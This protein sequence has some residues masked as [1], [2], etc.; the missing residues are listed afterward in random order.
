MLVGNLLNE[1]LSNATSICPFFFSPIFLCAVEDAH[2]NASR[3]GKSPC[4]LDMESDNKDHMRL[5]YGNNIHNI[6]RSIK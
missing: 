6:L 4:R 3:K 5:D 2:Q 1:I